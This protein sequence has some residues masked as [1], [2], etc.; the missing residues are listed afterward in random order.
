M[1]SLIVVALSAF[2]G[3]AF[4]QELA[5]SY[6]ALPIAEGI[7]VLQGEGGFGGGNIG[8]L[9]GQDFVT[10]ID[11]GLEPLAPLLL[12]SIE[13]TVGRPVN[14]II[15]THVHGD[16]AGGNAH[17]AAQGAVVFAHTNIRKRL[18]DDAKAAGGLRG[19]P[20]VTFDDGVAFHLNGLDA[21][22]FHVPGAHTDGDA[23]IHFAQADV[24]FTGDLLF[25]G[26]FPFIDLDSGGSVDG[27]IAAQQQLLGMIG[28]GTRVVPGHG[29]VTDRAG[30]AENLRVLKEA[31]QRVQALVAEGL[32]AD[33]VVA[34]N[35]L[36]DFHDEY[37]WGFITTERMTRTLYRGLT[38]KSAP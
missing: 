22:V 9:A 13:A 32:D 5:T 10:L 36:A 20:V 26:L 30:L 17:F 11:D 14:F 33:A 1:R 7:H 38:E 37:N 16:H 8:L 23:A 35:P 31:R 28:E 34:R 12:E 24:L 4:A 6:K 2:S 25:N 15:N 29:E 3:L 18:L 27:Y 21:Q 19:L